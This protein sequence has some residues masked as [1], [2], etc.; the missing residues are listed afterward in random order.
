MLRARGALA[1]GVPAVTEP[2]HRGR[3]WQPGGRSVL[4]RI[5]RASG[6]VQRFNQRTLAPER[7]DR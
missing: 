1:Y 4:R 7:S 3:R 6:E 5:R 2:D